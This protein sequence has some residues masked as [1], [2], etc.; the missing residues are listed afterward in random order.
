MENMTA[1][2]IHWLGHFVFNSPAAVH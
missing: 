1:L 2:Y